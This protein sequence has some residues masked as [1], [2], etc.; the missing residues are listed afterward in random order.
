MTTGDRPRFDIDSLR[1]IA[2]EKV[3]A[4]GE[5]YH[6]EGQVAI[7]SIEPKRVLAQVAGTEDYRTV[8]TGRGARIGGECSCAAF[9]DRGFCKHMVAAALAANSAGLDAQADGAGAL[10]RIR[11]YLKAKGDDALVAMILDYAEHDPVLFRRLDAAAATIGADDQTLEARLRKAIDAATRTSGF[12]DYHEAAGWASGVDSALDALADLAS[13]RHAGVAM[14]LAERALDRIARAVAEIDDSDGYCGGLLER[15]RDIHRAAAGAAHSEPI[16][17]ARD[18]FAR[19]MAD[20]HGTFEGAA[21]LYADALGTA[22]LDEYRRLA[23]AEWAKLPPRSARSER[24]DETDDRYGRLKSILDA[25]AAHDGDVAARIALRTKDLSAP[26]HYLQL[27]EFCQEQDQDEEALRWA[28]EGLWVFE[29]ERPDERLL[30]FAVDLL[31]K[32]GRNSEAEAQLWRCFETAP[33]LELYARLRKLMGKAVHPRAVEFLQARLAGESR[34]RWHSPADLLIRVQMQEASFDAAWAT[35]HAHGASADIKGAL[36][37]ASE[38]S[39]PREALAIYAERVDR[40]ADGGGNAAYA[41]A[42]ALIARMAVLRGAAEQAAY[43]A[44]LRARFGRKRNLMK[45]LE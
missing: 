33:S 37:R 7:L 38:S 13:G 27:A 17:L 21:T 20:G 24:R 12:V 9:G 4:R 2:G 35:V 22:G 15:A 34:T 14:K 29:D 44:A 26:W 25:F 41:E 30:F 19:E 45:L 28:T 39:H 5:A 10:A 36:A 3:F 40:L 1:E 31:C 42:A 23:A 8:L 32:A 6:R 43:V 18:L 11:E 16:A